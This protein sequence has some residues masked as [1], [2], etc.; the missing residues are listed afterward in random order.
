MTADLLIEI[1]TEE[2]PPKAL[3]GLEL[4]FAEGIRTR[5]AEANLQHGL[6]ESFATPRRLAVRVKKLATRQADQCV[7]RRGPP[8]SVAIDA[9]GA[10]TRA[11]ENFAQGC[12]VAVAALGREKAQDAKKG[13]IEYL[14][15]TGV[16][17]GSD[18]AALLPDMVRA[19][20][21]SLPV[22]KR[23]RWGSGEAQFVRPVHWVLL[24]LGREVIATSILGIAS[25][26]RTHGHRFMTPRALRV[27]SP[28]SYV[29]TLEKRGKVLVDFTARSERIRVGVE[30]LATQL[31]GRALITPALLEE[32]TALVE[33]PVPLAGQFEAR[34]LELPREVLIATLQEHQRYFPVEGSDGNLLPWFITVSNIESSAPELVRAGNERVVGPRLSDAA[35]FWELD[36]RTPLAAGLP[37]LDAVTFQAKLGSIG[38]KVRRVEALSV[39][40]AEAIG[41][42]AL[43]A[44]RAAQLAK[45]D[46]VSSL[47]GEFPELQG[48]MGAY[49]AKADGEAD[50]VVR[51]IREHYLPRGAGDALPATPVG[52]AVAIADKLDTL[53]GIFSIDLKPSGARDPFGLRRATIGVLRIIL[54]QRLS[55]D[56]NAL[57]EK[58][59]LAQPLDAAGLERAPRLIAEIQGYVM[60]RL[61]AMYQ[62][63]AAL[64]VT[65][66]I[67]D[68]VLATQPRSPLDF[69]ARLRALLGFLQLPE[70]ASLTAANKRIAN[71]LRKSAGG[72]TSANQL[73]PELLRLMQERD[74]YDGLLAADAAVSPAVA[75]GEYASALAQLARLRPA[76]DAF[77]DGVM[78]MD[79]D[80]ALRANRLA[81]LE[82]LRKLFVRIADLSRLPG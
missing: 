32:V 75:R 45:C 17:A 15:Y 46:L 8:V 37:L 71:L 6:L 69:D 10:A 55:L 38:A 54:Q 2:L 73:Q 16:K 58:A 26:D 62:E 23:M 11:G 68:A 44:Q 66:E 57:I 25:G 49:H 77:F 13:E 82:R 21:D 52:M 36:R 39:A 12:G 78:V 31:H 56:L 34:F 67:F 3:R 24:L 48:V 42:D 51:A 33:W 1:G 76:V 29:S 14:S 47:V 5:L 61:R 53:A 27:A 43:L 30:A 7:T 28:A 64:G 41:A 9:A 35:F 20:L 59:V 19:S 50:E 22:P 74:L 4:A 70:A 80:P 18:T 40:V 60:E 72:E 79:E 63:N 81:L 65:P